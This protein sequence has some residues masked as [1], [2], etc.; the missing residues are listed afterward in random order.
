MIDVTSRRIV[1]QYQTQFIIHRTFDFNQQRTHWELNTLHHGH[2][3]FDCEICITGN[4]PATLDDLLCLCQCL[5]N[6]WKLQKTLEKIIKQTKIKT[7]MKAGGNC[8]SLLSTNAHPTDIKRSET[9]HWP[10]LIHL[11]HVCFCFTNNLRYPHATADRPVWCVR[12]CRQVHSVERA[13]RSMGNRRRRVTSDPNSRSHVPQWSAPIS[14]W[15]TSYSG[16]LQCVEESQYVHF[17]I[18]VN[19]VLQ[20]VP[21]NNKCSDGARYYVEITFKSVHKCRHIDRH[22]WWFRWRLMRFDSW[23]DAL[24]IRL[25]TSDDRSYRG[26]NSEKY[27][28][29]SLENCAKFH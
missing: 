18:H 24:E 9:Q 22:C 29:R 27:R 3:I 19:K 5:A 17:E 21:G 20:P 26:S 10:L 4:V 6:Q 1:T 14:I 11:K 15:R 8:H 23:S 13:W 12:S 16:R 7:V 28:W 25:N 2:I